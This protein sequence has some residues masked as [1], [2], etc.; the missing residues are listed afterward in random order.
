MYDL[1]LYVVGHTARAQRAI[2]ELKAVLEPD[3]SSRYSLKII[4]VIENPELAEKK[5]ILATPTV[6]KNEPPPVRKVIGDF[7]EKEKVLAA[8]GMN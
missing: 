4:D 8:L 7:S 3:F 5:M 6:A 2:E 1:T